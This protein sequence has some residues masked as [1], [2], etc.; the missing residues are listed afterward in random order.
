[1]KIYNLDDHIENNC[2]ECDN[3]TLYY[4]AYFQDE[5]EP[6]DQRFCKEG[7][8]DNCGDV[9]TTCELFKPIQEK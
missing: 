9:V 5:F 1:M 8:N 4:D 2:T 6:V 3:F 7:K